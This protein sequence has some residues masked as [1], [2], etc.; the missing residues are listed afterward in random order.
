M[1][2]ALL[3]VVVKTAKCLPDLILWSLHNDDEDPQDPIV[4]LSL[5]QTVD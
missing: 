3:P 2:H 5:A 1:V 4:G